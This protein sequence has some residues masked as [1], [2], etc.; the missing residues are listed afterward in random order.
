MLWAV[1]IANY[2]RKR[3]N[4]FNYEP[5]GGGRVVMEAIVKS[6][7]AAR[8][9]TTNFFHPPETLVP[10]LIS[11]RQFPDK[12]DAIANV[13]E[14]ENRTTAKSGKGYRERSRMA[15]CWRTILLCFKVLQFVEVNGWEKS[16]VKRHP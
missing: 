7:C 1:L 16:F 9:G 8:V 3:N 2:D 6:R 4:V 13:P 11:T 12:E 5:G 10:I 14:E 15:W